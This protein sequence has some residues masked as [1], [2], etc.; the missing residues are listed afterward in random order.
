[1]PKRNFL[2]VDFFPDF[3]D[4]L[5][6][7]LHFEFRNFFRTFFCCIRILDDFI[8]HVQKKL[9]VQVVYRR[10]GWRLNSAFTKFFKIAVF[11]SFR[12]QPW[13]RYTTWTNNF[14][15][16]CL[17]KSSNIRMQQK[18]FRKKFRNSKCRSIFKTSRKSGK[19]STERKFLLG[20]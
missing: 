10:Q 18:K 7:L 1:M 14:F 8:K 6:M 17:T 15:W 4:V 2:S 11:V 20:N 5:K 3:R 9:F 13:R 12:R 19:K 16:R